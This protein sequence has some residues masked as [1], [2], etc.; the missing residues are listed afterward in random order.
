[1]YSNVSTVTIRIKFTLQDINMIQL[2]VQKKMMWQKVS[3]V[4]I[5]RLNITGIFKSDIHNY[6][7]ST[8]KFNQHYKCVK[9]LY[10]QT[11]LTL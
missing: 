11:W 10:F 4:T 5:F 7:N 3:I 6:S 8:A 1:M 2:N 9:T